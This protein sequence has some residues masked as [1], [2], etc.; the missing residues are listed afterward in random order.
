MELKRKFNFKTCLI[1]VY[2]LFAVFYLVIGFLP[3]EATEYMIS[4]SLSIPEIELS[5][6][7]TELELDD[8]G[9]E[10]PDKIVGSFSYA[11]N[12]T[13]LIGHSTTVFEDLSQVGAGSV[14]VYDGREYI[15]REAKTLAKDR[16]DMRKVLAEAEVDTI[17][18]M[19][20][21]G[22]L[23]GDGDATHRL[24]LTATLA[25]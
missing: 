10:T 24:I 13:L 2:V 14:V 15:V 9:L 8:E 16:I 19:T 1:A 18:M 25:E 21:A 7:V 12:K 22:E 5:A 11:E 17:V 4:S 6:E 3:A 23:F 20:C